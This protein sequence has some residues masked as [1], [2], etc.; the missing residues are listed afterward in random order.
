M[1]LKE[2]PAVTPQP[3]TTPAATPIPTPAPSPTVVA[4]PAPTAAAV[5]TTPVSTPAPKPTVAPVSPTPIPKSKPLG[6]LWIVLIGAAILLIGALVYLLIRRSKKPVKSSDQSSANKLYSGTVKLIIRV[7]S[8]SNQMPVFEEALR[9]SADLRVES[10]GGSS[11]EGNVIIVSIDK[12]KP[13]YLIEA[14]KSMT[15]VKQVIVENNRIVV[16]L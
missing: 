16:I 1:K 8:N 6:T 2:A 12:Q 14:L 11:E 9:K 4:S 5:V 15:E 13:I 3:I 7:P 10:V